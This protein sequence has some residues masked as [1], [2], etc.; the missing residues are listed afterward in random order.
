MRR[1]V[2]L[3]HNVPRRH[4]Q[5]EGGEL[6][7]GNFFAHEQNPGRG[8]GEAAVF[9]VR[10][11]GNAPTGYIVYIRSR[12]DGSVYAEFENDEGW[13]SLHVPA[14]VARQVSLDAIA[15]AAVR[16]AP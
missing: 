1:P 4:S 16:N 7:E 15:I 10:G 11:T 5:Y 13:H 2:P 14:N 8:A 6:M 12:T 3:I 9:G